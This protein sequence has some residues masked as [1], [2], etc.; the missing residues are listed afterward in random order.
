M[1]EM[2]LPSNH[3]SEIG[4][5]SIIL[6]FSNSLQPLPVVPLCDSFSPM[7]SLEIGQLNFHEREPSCSEEILMDFQQVI[8]IKL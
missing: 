3:L 5:G 6:S 7:C 1:A 8:N 4:N 2:D